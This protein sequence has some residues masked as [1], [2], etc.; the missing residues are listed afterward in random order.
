LN[1]KQLHIELFSEE[2]DKMSDSILDAKE[3]AKGINPMSKK[4]QLKVAKKREHLG[5]SPLSS[6]GDS[7][8]DSSWELC[9]EECE[10]RKNKLKTL[11]TVL[12]EKYLTEIKK[13][14]KK[15]IEDHYKAVLEIRNSNS[16]H[17]P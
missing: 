14:E 8:D 10:A 4:Y 12:I 9:K 11:K 16:D 5:V 6:S 15:M 7:V 2:Y 1:A 13:N 17:K 3:R